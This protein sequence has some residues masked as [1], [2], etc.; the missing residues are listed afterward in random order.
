MY[1]G[2]LSVQAGQMGLR[3][4]LFAGFKGRLRPFMLLCDQFSPTEQS[5][6][7]ELRLNGD[8]SEKG[9]ELEWE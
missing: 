8:I 1:S 4:S 2:L 3:V 5:I 6:H 9:L 7:V